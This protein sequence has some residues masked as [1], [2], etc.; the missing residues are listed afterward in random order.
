MLPIDGV[1]MDLVVCLDR[2]KSMGRYW[3]I[4]IVRP[5]FL[6][7]ACAMAR[8]CHVCICARTR[9]VKSNV[10][11]PPPQET[12]NKGVTKLTARDRLGTRTFAG[13]RRSQSVL[14]LTEMSQEG[15]VPAPPPRNTHTHT[16]TDERTR[17]TDKRK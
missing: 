3:P 14:E 6:I 12:L 11:W 2:S 8:A 10:Q 16:H 15:Q 17:H 7:C 4:V 9:T 1:A 5:S 13:Q